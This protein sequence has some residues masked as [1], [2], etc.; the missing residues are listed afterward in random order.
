MAVAVPWFN[1]PFAGGPDANYANCGT[2]FEDVINRL[3][4]FTYYG[5]DKTGI[6]T[7]TLDPQILVV[8]NNNR[9]PPGGGPG[10]LAVP[11]LAAAATRM[12][13]H[14]EGANAGVAIAAGVIGGPLPQTGMGGAWQF[15]DGVR[16]GIINYLHNNYNNAN[17]RLVNFGGPGAGAGAAVAQTDAIL[18]SMYGNAINMYRARALLP[19]RNHVN[20]VMHNSLIT[21]YKETL[22]KVFNKLIEPV[23]PAAVAAAGLPI[24]QARYIFDTIAYTAN[25]GNPFNMAVQNKYL[26]YKQ[27]YLT[28]KNEK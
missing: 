12:D 18:E 22:L 6:P 7:P 5:D 26:K 27:K 17:F 28:L 20:A 10:L 16:A 8:I 11:A 1:V 19:V 25:T 3:I 15:A 14:V 24:D 2:N 21:V 13:A 9:P 23:P 4:D